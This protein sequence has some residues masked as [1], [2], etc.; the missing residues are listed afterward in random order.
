[1]SSESKDDNGNFTCSVELPDGTK[2]KGTG[3]RKKLAQQ[4]AC[5]IVKK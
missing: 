3:K 1:L 5:N 2:G 4:R